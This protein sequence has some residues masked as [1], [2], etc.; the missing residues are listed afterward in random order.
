MQLDIRFPTVARN[1]TAARLAGLDVEEVRVDLEGLA[2]ATLKQDAGFR[3]LARR[4]RGDLEPAAVRRE[5]L[6]QAMRLSPSMA[7][8]LH[9][10]G[11]EVS[12]VLGIDT[13]IEL[14]QA[15]GAENAV[16]HLVR[17]PMLMEVQGRLLSLL[18]DDALRALLGHEMGHYLAHGDADGSGADRITARML[19]RMP[20][21]PAAVLAGA[22][23]HSLACELTADRFALLACQD[24]H[25][26][27]RLEMIC[28]TGL[29]GDVISW[30]THAYL[31]NCTELMESLLQDG[32]LARGGTHPEHSLRAYALWL[33]SET[34]LYHR[35]TGQG[36][37]RRRLADVD[38]LLGR[39]VGL[40]P[41]QDDA[42][43]TLFEDPLTEI[44]ECAL[45]GAVMVAW[46]DGELDESETA[47]IEAV[48]APLVAEWAR[49]L[50]LDVALAEFAR[51]LPVMRASDP[52]H[53]RS[54]FHI[55]VHVMA[56]DG[57][58]VHDE[59]ATILGIGEALGRLDEFRQML[60]GTLAALDVDLGPAEIAPAPLAVPRAEVEEALDAFLAGVRRRG[61][62]RATVER[63]LR[64]IGEPARTASGVARLKQAFAE[65]EI[66]PSIDL[67]QAPLEATVVLDASPLPVEQ[68]PEEP[69]TGARAELTKALVRLRDKL[70]S[71]D[72]RSPS[73]RLR[74]ARKGRVFDLFALE[75]VKVGLALRTLTGIQAGRR[76]RLVSAEEA[77]HHRGALRCVEA[78][79]S[80][81]RTTRDRAEETGAN[82]LF[83]GHPV[84]SGVVGRGRGRYLVRAPLV[85][86]PVDLVR[87]ARGARG[88]TVVPRRGEDPVVN[89]A[90]IRATFN[91]LGYALTDT[92]ADELDA[93]AADDRQGTAGVL[94]RLSEVGLDIVHHPGA[95]RRFETMP[96]SEDDDTPGPLRV[97]ECALL[98]IFPQSNSDLLQDYD[99]IVRDL[100]DSASELGERLAAGR[101]LL[102]AK[103]RVEIRPTAPLVD[104]LATRSSV[105]ASD[106]SQKDVI[107][108]TRR[109]PL[110][111]IDG[112]P[113][114]GKSQV[115]VNLV[116]DAIAR[117]ERVAVVC[118]KRAAL[119]VVSQRL[120]G[121][122]LDAA[123]A[124]VHDLNDDRR[125]LF[126]QIAAR[127]EA[128]APDPFDPHEAADFRRAA[129]RS[130]EELAARIE[131]LGRTLP[132]SA[133][134]YGQLLLLESGTDAPSLEGP[135][136]A[137]LAEVSDEARPAL[138]RLLVRLHTLVDVWCRDGQWRGPSGERWPS[139]VGGGF[140]ETE[141]TLVKALSAARAFEADLARAT[142]SLATARANEAALVRSLECLDRIDPARSDDVAR[143]LRRAIDEPGALEALDHARMAEQEYGSAMVAVGHREVLRA[144][145][146]LAPAIATLRGWAGRIWRFFIPGWWKARATIHRTTATLLPDLTGQGVG[147][148]L[149]DAI[150]ARFS[151][152]LGWRTI[153]THLARLGVGGLPDEPAALVARLGQLTDA[154][155][156]ART[157]AA[158]RPALERL[159]AWPEDFDPPDWPGWRAELERWRALLRA[160]ESYTEAVT[161]LR[162]RFPWIEPRPSASTLEGLL[163][164]FRRDAPRLA[165]VDA[166]L[167]GEAADSLPEILPLADALHR[168]APGA[169][170]GRWTAAVTRAWAA[171]RRRVLEADDPA[172][173]ELGT[174]GDQ[175]REETLATRL[176]ELQADLQGIELGWIR[177]RLGQADILTAPAREKYARKTPIQAAR[178]AMLKEVGKKRRLMPLRSFVRTYATE[179]LLDLLPVWLMSPE[180]MAVLFPRQPMF[181]LVIFDEASQC[182]VEAGFPVLLRAR[183]AIVVGDEHQMPPTSF[184][185]S[186]DTDE[187]DLSAEEL[188]VRDIFASE[189][190]LTLARARCEHARLEWHYRCQFE[191]LIA[192]SNH[193]IYD[194]GLRT[195]PAINTPHSAGAIRWVDVPDAH[196]ESGA[197]PTEAE[198]VVD[199]VDTCLDT[200]P[201]ESVGIIT[202]NLKQRRAILDA[203]DARRAQDD[204]FDARWSAAQERPVDSRPF[205][206][207]LESVQGDERDVIIFSLGHAPRRR[208]RG[209]QPTDELY[210]PARFGPLGQRG[211]ERRL[212]VA[213]SRARRACHIVSSFAPNLLSVGSATHRGPYLFKQFI[214]Y[215]Y[216]LDRG[217]GAEARRILDGLRRHDRR[218]EQVSYARTPLG[219]AGLAA[220][221]ALALEAEGVPLERNVGASDFRVPVALFDPD[222]PHRFAL[223]ILTDDGGDLADPLDLHVHR[224]SVLRSRGWRVMRITA[225]TWARRRDEVL[226]AIFDAVPNAPGALHRPLWQKVNRG[227][228]PPAPEPE[229]VIELDAQEG[230]Q[231]GESEIPRKIRSLVA[232]LEERGNVDREEVE[233]LAGPRGFRRLLIVLERLAESGDLKFEW[234]V[235]G[236][237]VWIE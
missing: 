174:L 116:A 208:I 218:P 195:V 83:V 1:T 30:D 63:L 32:D 233:Q 169:S 3:M 104:Q 7:P 186:G 100:G 16:M 177:S 28:T 70:V 175:Q 106:P 140:T 121:L 204:E 132:G 8:D 161:A 39:L 192:F 159:G 134:S 154:M 55:L 227:S 128:P 52:V 6:A 142:A 139:V 123:V 27:L 59:I 200:R 20:D 65:N 158:L 215:A 184:F 170:A 131:R 125:P 130:T 93:L 14:Y 149:V 51:T 58:I 64:L 49:Y 157:L 212:N 13:P 222:N 124:V 19:L 62:G 127:F 35:L 122:G 183:R 60:A 213:I 171:A 191:S 109:H 176:T 237:V 107:A 168:A 226:A 96:A 164:A 82:D 162:A 220:Q 147:R 10:I 25:A 135:A 182:T 113:G 232:R 86:H 99:G 236:D 150:D 92:L 155:S 22:R 178:E 209:G 50:A 225:A 201:E 167:T 207:N 120:E 94:A 36:T 81:E 37:G 189:S 61:R 160:E 38:D 165:D 144:P 187:D 67:E 41:L 206:K 23:I 33:F 115:I 45:A 26:A 56:V 179:G 71:G 43:A 185:K 137:T 54:M 190:L 21:T 57:H 126:E 221:V 133:L 91:K 12:A 76:Q 2:L 202:F 111:V 89:Q 153:E 114:T 217:R 75:E 119:D 24:L 231:D 148:A 219:A 216:C 88:Y 145:P 69:L 68:R 152:S 194:G 151:A 44:H 5:L 17:S 79:I 84:L 42:A 108:R 166:C 77:G 102:P 141:G 31:Q 129:A 173:L 163:L 118:E 181:D 211:G 53:R 214:E 15:A 197:N 74:A 205:T 156:D 34:G 138:E 72:G 90:L 223:A 66:T 101:E 234:K 110:M 48:F 143:L 210:V 193:A 172:L 95:L 136:A 9:R 188:A 105:L 18:D 229:A 112:P 85:L 196:Y 224:P 146:D 203:I 87:D 98:G 228:T 199:L 235:Q 4:T 230:F 180:T 11:H 103:L 97:E 46:A 80:L 40:A 117:G 198:R 47:A 29:S 73:V 78:L